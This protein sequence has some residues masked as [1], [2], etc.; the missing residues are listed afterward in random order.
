MCSTVAEVRSWLFLRYKELETNDADKLNALDAFIQ[1]AFLE[2]CKDR[3]GKNYCKALALY[4][5]H[6]YSLSPFAGVN[7]GG[8]GSLTK[9][10]VGDIE[11]GYSAAP[12]GQSSGTGF[13]NK[14]RYGQAFESLL[15]TTVNRTRLPFAA[16]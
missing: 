9:E 6:Y 3:F 12:G 14:S 1:D 10:K 13:Y 4:A 8:G 16:C 2:L 15:K 5:A 11:K 7:A